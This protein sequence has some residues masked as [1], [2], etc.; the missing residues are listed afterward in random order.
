MY[1][2]KRPGRSKIAIY[3]PEMGADQDALVSNAETS[4]VY[5]AMADPDR[6][7]M[8]YQPRCPRRGSSTTK[9]WCASPGN[10]A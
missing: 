4:A 8:H 7:E 6:L 9:R 2:A 3:S 5:E 1:Y 10:M